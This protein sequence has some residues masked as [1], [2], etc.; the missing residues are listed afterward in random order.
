MPRQSRSA[1]EREESSLDTSDIPD[2]WTTS[3]LTKMAFAHAL[4]NYLP[5]IDAQ[6]HLL[7]R[8]GCIYEKGR[9]ICAST[10]HR[11]ALIAKSVTTGTFAK[12]C[13]YE[14]A[15]DDST[16]DSSSDDAEEAEGEG[17]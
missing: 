17:E 5:K 15:D 9:T 12:P 16:S 6:Y 2:K 4:A 13:I 11:D 10:A 3:P 8:E 7:V 14:A 1:R